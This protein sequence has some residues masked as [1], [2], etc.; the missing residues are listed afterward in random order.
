MEILSPDRTHFSSYKSF[1]FDWRSFNNSRSQDV[2]H[3]YVGDNVIVWDIGL[4]YNII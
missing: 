1:K 4:V 3:K 2:K